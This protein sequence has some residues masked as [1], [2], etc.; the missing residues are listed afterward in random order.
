MAVDTG[1][2]V[3]SF[4]ILSADAS[5]SYD[6]IKMRLEEYSQLLKSDSPTIE[7]STKHGKMIVCWKQADEMEEQLQEAKDLLQAMIEA[8]DVPTIEVIHRLCDLATVLDQFKLQEECLVIGDCAIKLAQALGLRAL[9]FQ[10]EQAQTIALIAG[11]DAYESRARHLFIQAISVCEAFAI[12][13][14][15]DSAKFT[16]LEV[17]RYSGFRG[18][19]YPVLCAQWLDR[20]VDL[21][22][23]LPSAMVTDVHR[24]S[25][26]TSYG[27]SLIALKEHSKAL[28]ITEKAI[29]YTR[30][31]T[32]G[33]G[34]ASH[35]GTLP[36]TL[37]N[38][39]IILSEMGRHE[40][41]LSVRQEAVTL[42]RTLD[43]DGQGRNK[44]FTNALLSYGTT[45]YKMGRHEDALSVKQEAVSLYRAL[46]VDG[47]EQ[48]EGLADALHNYGNTLSCMGRHDDALSVRQEAVSLYRTLN[49]DG[50]EQNKNLAGALHGYGI[51][52]SEM[53]RHE[54]ALSV[55]QEAVALYRTLD[56]D[57]QEKC[58][59]DALHIYGITL[60]EMGRHEDALSVGQEAVALYR[61]LDVDG[62]E[63]SLADALHI[64]GNTLSDMGRHED[65]PS[66]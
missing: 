42:Y 13:D 27:A 25:I 58:L 66:V 53:G 40:D 41:A 50:Q 47:Q 44:H 37:H 17:L 19:A 61:T 8:R 43:V 16:L 1:S 34:H 7:F 11:L 30:S 5:L 20:A 63:Q 65:A 15:S 26:Y 46:I 18:Y 57:G 62:Q 10:K 3:V 4:S 9:E 52:L 56:V 54:D 48:N 28:A 32:S 45:L 2:S 14:G 39:G 29:A 6:Q 36:F 22:A 33:H 24:A 59:A 55:G 31:L 35:N 60:Y 51:T 21:I 23:E 38:Y 12:E 64:Y 49:V